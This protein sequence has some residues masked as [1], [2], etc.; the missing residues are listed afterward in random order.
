[1]N[2][3]QL[4]IG[5]AAAYE[6]LA[7]EAAEMAQAVLKV[8][9]I[10]RNENPTPVSLTDALHNLT[11]EFSDLLLCAT[12]VDASIDEDAICFKYNRWIERLKEVGKL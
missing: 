2:Q 10:L 9:R 4:A 12:L 3:I 1:M 6:Q 11:E 7:E 5:K 8:S